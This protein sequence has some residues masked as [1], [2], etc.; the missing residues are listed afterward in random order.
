MMTKRNKHTKW[1]LKYVN[2]AIYQYQMVQ[3]GDRIAVAVSGGKDSLTLLRL[4]NLRRKSSKEQYEIIAV[5]ISGDSEGPRTQV[6][7]PLVDWFEKNGYRYVIQK[8]NLSPSEKLPMDCQRCSWNRKKQLFEIAH[9][10]NCNVVAFGH[11][12]DDLAETTLMNLLFQSK[13]KT[14]PPV[15][16]YFNG[17]FRLIRPL[18]LIPEKE[19]MKFSRLCK[20]PPPP[21]ECDQSQQSQ[22]FMVKNFIEEN[23]NRFP[24]MRKNLIQ[25]GLRAQ[26]SLLERETTR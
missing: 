26:K 12:A 11:N 20:F 4:L 5:H 15:S 23:H 19:M 17:L 7:Q 21:P 22:R 3:S 16:E 1:L 6:H 10:L 18:V 2:K 13:V 24:N 25:A 8:F 9:Q 14:I